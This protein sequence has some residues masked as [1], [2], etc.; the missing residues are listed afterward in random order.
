MY[1]V[2]ENTITQA[3]FDAVRAGLPAHVR[4]LRRLS[5]WIDIPFCVQLMGWLAAALAPFMAEVQP[6]FLFDACT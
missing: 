5:A 1:L 3:E 4:L 2:N 6:L